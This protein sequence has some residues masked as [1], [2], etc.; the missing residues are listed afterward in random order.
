MSLLTLIRSTV[1]GGVIWEFG[2]SRS[3]GYYTISARNDYICSVQKVYRHEILSDDGDSN[4]ERYFANDFG[5]ASSRIAP[6]ISDFPKTTAVILRALDCGF[7]IGC[8]ANLVSSDAIDIHVSEC[9][10]EAKMTFDFL[11]CPERIADE[12]FATQLITLLQRCS[13][14]GYLEA[15]RQAAK[16]GPGHA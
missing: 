6:T 3:S 13:E 10:V 11:M 2:K 9:D 5:I 7:V 4:L 8:K 15:S 1:R 16:E 12:M 14:F